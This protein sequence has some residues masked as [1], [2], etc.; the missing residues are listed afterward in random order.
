[1]ASRTPRGAARREWMYFYSDLKG[2]E[3]HGLAGVNIHTGATNRA[4]RIKD[5]DE[6][7]VTDEV[8]GMLYSASANR[9][10]G[11]SVQR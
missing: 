6:R 3:G 10:L 7:F 11:Y 1:M 9:P 2:V 4:I 8:V 5:L